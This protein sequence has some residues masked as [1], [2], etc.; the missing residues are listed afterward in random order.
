MAISTRLA[1][2]RRTTLMT[3]LCA[4]LVAGA[5]GTRHADAAPIPQ[6]IPV[7]NCLDDGSDGSLRKAI[8]SAGIGDTIDMSGLTCSLITLQSGQLVSPVAYLILKGPGVDTLTID[9]NNADR[10]LQGATLDIS[11]LSIAHGRVTT[12]GGCI[13]ATGALA[14]TR[15]K[16]FS[17][18][19]DNSTNDGVGG[20]AIVLGNLTMD[21]SAIADNKVLGAAHA[22]GGGVAVGGTAYLNYSSLSGNT[23]DADQSNAYGGALYAMGAITS[24]SSTIDGNTAH[25]SQAAVRGGGIAAN[26]GLEVH[27]TS[28]SGNKAL[29]VAGLA[30]GGGIHSMNAYDVSILDG[31][32]ITGNTVHSDTSWAY[33]GGI[34]SGLVAS[35]YAATVRVHGSTVSGNVAESGCSACSVE[36]GG[37]NATDSIESMYSTFSNNHATCTNAASAC[38]ALGGGLAM[39]GILPTSNTI[40]GQVTISSNDASSGQQGIGNGGGV[41]AISFRPIAATNATIAYNHASSAGGGIAALSPSV[42]SSSLTSVIVADNDDSTGPDDIATGP[43]QTITIDGSNDLVM[44]TSMSVTLPANTLGADPMLMPLTTGNGGATA[45]HPLAAG[46]PAIDAGAN[47]DS[48]GCDQRGAPYSRVVGASADIG[49]YEFQGE[50]PLFADGFDGVAVIVACSPP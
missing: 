37:V 9:G 15:A 20:G 32:S 28:V 38:N 13:L 6:I 41:V 31:S 30:F 29:A 17:C 11:D 40:L 33:G 7:T 23:A 14:L 24:Y 50:P 46:S 48:L 45:V 5:E 44:A 19:V 3:C 22:I 39:Y 4:A 2:A 10:V 42:P 26:S 35:L 1:V 27:A 25:S 49:A 43:G 12:G 47:P 8:A 36:G 18:Y 21:T 16:I 34:N